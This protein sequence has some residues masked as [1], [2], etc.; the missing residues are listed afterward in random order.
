MKNFLTILFLFTALAS[1]GQYHRHTYRVTPVNGTPPPTYATWNPSDKAAGIT[2]SGGNLTSAGTG[3]GVEMVRATVVLSGLKYWEIT[4][5]TIGSSRTGFAKSAESL[6]NYMGTTTDSY[7]K[8]E[9]NVYWY[10]NTPSYTG[11]AIANG[12][13]IMVAVNTSTGNAWWGRNGTWDNSGN[14]ATGANPA[15]TGISGS[16]YPAFQ[17]GYSAA[18]MTANFGAT[19]FTY[20]P[21]SGFSGVY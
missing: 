21:P 16:F 3:S 5:T 14:P 2:L 1:Q 7:G 18:T 17:S 10:N 6:S 19:A 15:F 12:D 4:A 11:T 13:T 20:T 9:D 8:A